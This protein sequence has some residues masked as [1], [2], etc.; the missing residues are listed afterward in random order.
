MD[1]GS[2]SMI[3]SLFFPIA[4]FWLLLYI[5][6]DREL[7]A[8]LASI[9]IYAVLSPC[10]ANC[11]HFLELIETHLGACYHCETDRTRHRT[12][13]TEHPITSRSLSGRHGE[14]QS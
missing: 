4:L 7:F 6:H 3:F 2:D 11:I 1:F 13:N 12:R 8:S 10:V 14:R 5:L 9:N